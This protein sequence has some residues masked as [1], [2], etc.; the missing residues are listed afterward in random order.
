MGVY[1]NNLGDQFGMFV[2]MPLPCS[3]WE[4]VPTSGP[5]SSWPP[6]TNLPLSLSL[7]LSLSSYPPPPL[8]SHPST[9]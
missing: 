4:Q 6:A 3:P 7:S 1:V 5:A 2:M 9:V 8:S